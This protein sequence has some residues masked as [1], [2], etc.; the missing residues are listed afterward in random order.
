MQTFMRRL[1][2]LAYLRES[3]TPKTTGQV[4]AHL[5]GMGHLDELASEP[6][7]MR[8]IQRDLNFLLGGKRGTE[9]D[10]EF[11]LESSQGEGRTVHWWLDPYAGL[12]FDYE[13]MPQFLALSFALTKKHLSHLLPQN[14][15]AELERF[16][17][18]A[19]Q[20]LQKLETSVSPQHLQRLSMAVE[21]YQRGQPL[22]AAAFDI[23]HLDTI[24]RAIIQGRQL[25]MDYRGKTYRLHPLG[26]AI[27]LPKL[28]LVARKADDCAAEAADPA[29]AY[30]SFLVHKIESIYI[31]NQPAELTPSFSLRQ[32]LDQGYMDVP[33]RDS[34]R[35]LLALQLELRVDDTSHLIESLTE[36]PLSADQKL[37]RVGDGLWQLEASVRHTV[38][39]RNW[40][41][42]LGASG[43]V[44]A[45][46]VICQDLKHS[47]QTMLARYD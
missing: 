7:Q 31:D 28:Y 22:Q 13:K 5:R 15:L 34:C 27:L 23:N 42:S 30:R 3:R 26:V 44:L 10:N 2:I 47:L 29:S 8:L 39:L 11:G 37:H 20:R 36:S 40:L 43:K 21:F 41:L 14:T 1:A 25:V 17:L 6:T 33:V 19:E 35:G 18:Q 45:P 9:P 32:W 4:V 16:F 24:Y 12:R 38:Q 46:D